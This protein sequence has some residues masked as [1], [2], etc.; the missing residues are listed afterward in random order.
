MSRSPFRNSNPSI[1]CR[2]HFDRLEDPRRHGHY[3]SLSHPENSCRIVCRKEDDSYLITSLLLFATSIPRKKE[4]ERERN[5]ITPMRTGLRLVR[6]MKGVAK[7]RNC[8]AKHNGPHAYISFASTQERELQHVR[9][10][11]WTSTFEN[12]SCRRV[13]HSRLHGAAFSTRR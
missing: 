1:T 7:G 2:V 10:L 13:R 6:Y 5:T 9:G 12:D 11:L 4:S 8:A 3:C